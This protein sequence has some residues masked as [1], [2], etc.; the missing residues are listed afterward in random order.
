MKT[1][2]KVK[3][4][5]RSTFDTLPDEAYIRLPQVLELYPV[6]KSTWWAG[7]ASGKYP[8]GHKLSAHI[9]AWRKG[10]ICKLLNGRRNEG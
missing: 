5:N 8:P 3:L 7:V 6:S 10:D 1:Q 4:M 9:T 2:Q